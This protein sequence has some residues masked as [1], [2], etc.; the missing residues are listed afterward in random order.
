MSCEEHVRKFKNQAEV[1]EHCGGDIGID[2]SRVDEV[3]GTM[4]LADPAKPTD[5][6]MAQ[7]QKKAQEEYM[8]VALLLSA[9]WKRYGKL[10]EELENDFLMGTNNYPQ[11]QV[12]THN[13][14]IHWKQDPKNLMRVLGTSNDGVAFANLGRS[15]RENGSKDLSHIKCYNRQKM[16]HYSNKCPDREERQESGTSQLMAGVEGF[17]DYDDPYV[18]FQFLQAEILGHMTKPKESNGNTNGILHNQHNQK[19]PHNW[20]LLGNQSTVDVFSNKKLLKNVQ[21]ATT[22]MNIKCNAGV[23]R[24]N[25]I[26][27]LTGYV[28]VWYNEKGI[29]NILSMSKVAEKYRITYDSTGDEGF[30]IHRNEGDGAN[31]HFKKARSGLFYLDVTD[32]SGTVLLV[33]TVDDNKSKYTDR[34]Y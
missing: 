33:T 17:D 32:Q 16:G 29:A 15:E 12:E 11:T 20:I 1:V 3:L 24:T 21:R 19:V 6:E 2:Q 25:M 5:D 13:S 18:N 22:T 31:R 4:T 7:A 14:M 23:T 27:D 10:I 26:G 9:D 30:V 28:P 8:A 34:A